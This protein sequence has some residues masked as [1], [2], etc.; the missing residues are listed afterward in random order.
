MIYVFNLFGGEPN[1]GRQL[2]NAEKHRVKSKELAFA[3]AKAMVKNLLF[4]GRRATVCSITDQTGSII[5][6]VM[7]EALEIA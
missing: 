1:G 3:H 2:L 7:T 6:E 5:G 4:D